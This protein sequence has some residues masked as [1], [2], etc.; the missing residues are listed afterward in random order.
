M[1]LFSRLLFTAFVLGASFYALA[2]IWTKEVDITA[3]FKKASDA[4]PVKEDKAKG[5]DV[6][7]RFVNPIS[8]MGPS[9]VLENLSDEVASQIKYCFALINYDSPEPKVPLP[10]PIATFDFL[11]GKSTGGPQDVFGPV[12][13]RLKAEDRIYG[14]ISVLS[15]GGSR[16][17]T[18]WVY[19]V[20]GKGGWL[21]E[22]EEI[23]S[24]EVIVP[25][26]F[27]KEKLDAFFQLVQSLPE[28]S[29]IP[30]KNQVH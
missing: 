27:S 21:S 26:N 4:I 28:Q 7:L 20:W 12:A 1:L 16:G 23:K 9:L 11:N 18:Y 30:I 3:L 22:A 14:S 24:G 6:I 19:F 17:H 10:I 13:H 15:R 8:P 5:A 29:R 25:A 2:K